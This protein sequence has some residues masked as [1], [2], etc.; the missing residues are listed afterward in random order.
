MSELRC[1]GCGA[2]LD[3]AHGNRK[4]CSERCRKQT[5]Y[6]GTCKTCGARTNG[7]NGLGTASDTCNVCALQRRHE[8]R[9]WTPE[10]IVAAMQRWATRHGRQPTAPDWR[11]AG[12]DYPAASTVQYEFDGS[13]DAAVLAAGFES[14]KPQKGISRDEVVRLYCSGLSAVSVARALDVHVNT[15]Y[16]HLRRTRERV[17][18]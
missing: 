14:Q 6:G 13:W 12:E 2:P 8:G 4:W 3:G 9:R 17:A 5:A 15:V 11:K 16:W 18:A 7:S 10:T 1:P